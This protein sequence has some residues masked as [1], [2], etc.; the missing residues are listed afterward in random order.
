VPA[1]LEAAAEHKEVQKASRHHA[2][3]G[4]MQY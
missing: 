3:P 1:V 4:S 2:S